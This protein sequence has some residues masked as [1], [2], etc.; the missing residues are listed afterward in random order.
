MRL[1]ETE[2]IKK[3]SFFKPRVTWGILSLTGLLAISLAAAPTL[4]R[5]Q[6]QKIMVDH[7]C[8]QI[9]QI[10]QAAILAARQ[11]LHIA[12]GHTSHG[13]QL[14]TGMDGL[15]DFMNGKGYPHDL[16][17]W[18]EGGSEGAL[19][20][21]DYAMDGDAGYYPDWVNN[22]RAYLGA[23]N[24]A[25]RGGNHPD[26]NVIVWS[27]CG[28]VSG[29]SE[30]EMIGNYLTP[31]SNLEIEYPGIRFVYM[32]GHLDGSGNSGNLNVRNNQIRNYCDAYNKVLYDF[33]D[34]E[35]YDPDG[36]INYM[37][38]MADDGCNYDSDGDG[39]NDKNWAL[40]WQNSHTL[41]VDWYDCYPEHTE[42]L[43]GNL[44]AYAA[45]W[46][47][48]RLAGWSSGSGLTVT[49][50]NGGEKWNSG[51]IHNIAW[52]SSGTIANVRIEFS[53]D[54][55]SAWNNVTAATAN[56]GSYAWTIPNT[57]S[58][59]CL[60]RVSDAANSTTSD[61]SNAVFSI[62]PVPIITLFAP[63]G[64]ETWNS[65]SIHDIIWASTGT[66]ANVRIELSTDNG[67]G[68][69]NVIAATANDGIYSWIVPNTPSSRCLVRISDA[70]NAAVKD[71]SDTFFVIMMNLDLQAERREVRAFSILRYY[72]RIQFSV[73]AASATVVQYRLMRRQGIGNFALLRAIA[74]SELQNN[75]FSMQDKYLEKDIPYTYRVE[76]YDAVGQLV[77]ISLEKTI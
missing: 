57:T 50:P 14:I 25:G 61:T 29:L 63:N 6:G 77:G 43:N 8:V 3:H 49:A 47:W 52:A 5:L 55:G 21:R 20:I 35:S 76:A 16:Y 13:S 34:I 36:L 15:V 19:D 75:R 72:G 1:R 33:A 26:I 9:A 68:W 67:S 12:Y 32:T 38:L 58:S 17:A 48:A 24:S 27:W 64:G 37:S 53:T 51:T 18:N 73:E 65:G 31:M 7:H 62:V 60:V 10:P 40:D 30:Q 45:W 69:N 46:L 54:N 4:R 59:Q 56:D 23:A 28:Q 41:N 66:I 22:T 42:A 11:N 71:A 2:I 74:P 70:A 39:S 44:K